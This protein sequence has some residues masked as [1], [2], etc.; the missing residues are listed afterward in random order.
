MSTPTPGWSSSV[1]QHLRETK[2]IL[3]RVVFNPKY[4]RS[5]KIRRVGGLTL[6][7]RIA[8]TLGAV[9]VE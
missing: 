1:S 5:V 7:C 6:I 9:E 8:G 3:Q 4:V 2:E